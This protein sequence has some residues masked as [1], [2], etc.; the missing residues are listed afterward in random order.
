MLLLV[1]IS[2]E[3]KEKKNLTSCLFFPAELNP[4]AKEE[5][6]AKR[7][8]I[9]ESFR[10]APFEDIVARSE[11]KVKI[12]IVGTRKV[13]NAKSLRSNGKGTIRCETVVSKFTRAGAVNSASAETLLDKWV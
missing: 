9:L 13:F 6:E 11:A 8:K 10:N 3:S 1:P 5:Q 7:R 4:K 2:H 12:E